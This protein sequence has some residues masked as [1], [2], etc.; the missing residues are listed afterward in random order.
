LERF[1]FYL[2]RYQIQNKNHITNLLQ[3]ITIRITNAAKQIK[4][5][6]HAA[7]IGT[8]IQNITIVVILNIR[9]D[10]TVVTLLLGNGFETSLYKFNIVL[11]KYTLRYYLER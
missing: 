11:Y 9:L 2:N 4:A 8:E 10:K 7:T 6:I 3:I 5:A 1:G